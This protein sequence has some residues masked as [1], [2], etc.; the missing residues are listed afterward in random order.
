MLHEHALDYRTNPVDCHGHSLKVKW[1]SD[2]C[3]LSTMIVI[4]LQS[5]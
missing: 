3:N 4:C 2:D 1:S 5:L